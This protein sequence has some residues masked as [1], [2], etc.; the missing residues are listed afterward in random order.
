[1]EGQFPY[2][3]SLRTSW[4]MHFCGGA[5]LNTRWILS[6]AHCTVFLEIPEIVAGSIKASEG[7][8]HYAIGRII[9]HPNYN[10]ERDPFADE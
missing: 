8:E 9:N 6:A 4:N 7:G 2:L 3:V 10:S 5:I 1:M